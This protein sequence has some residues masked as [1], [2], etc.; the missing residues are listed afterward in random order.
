MPAAQA[1]TTCRTRLRWRR[2]RRTLKPGAVADIA[3][4]DLKE[5]DFEFVDNYDTK[6]IGHHRLVGQAVI[7]NGK[8]V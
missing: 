8:R 7:V 1:S 2:V 3:V 4:L 6:R 5:G